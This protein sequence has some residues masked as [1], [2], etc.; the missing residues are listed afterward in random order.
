LLDIESRRAISSSYQ[1]ISHTDEYKK[2]TSDF[3]YI[4]TKDQVSCIND[5]LKDI[6]LIKPMNRVICG[7]VGFGK[8]EI[9]MRAAFVCVQAKKQA[10][11]L[12][13]STILSKQHLESF[14]KRF[15][16]FPVNI[17][18]NKA[19]FKPGKP[20]ATMHLMM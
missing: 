8:T 16:N 20:V 10:M 2:F 7:D 18:M 17:S 14:T 12:A 3:P 11:I 19:G 6:S 15:I 5:V 9:A 13:P 1:L 4:P